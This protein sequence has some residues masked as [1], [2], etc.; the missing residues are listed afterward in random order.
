MSQRWGSSPS[1]KGCLASVSS[2]SATCAASL[3]AEEEAQR[4]GYMM[5]AYFPDAGLTKCAGCMMRAYFP[6]AGPYRRDLYPNL[7][8]K[9]IVEFFSAAISVSVCR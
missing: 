9:T 4:A 2:T 8:G 5:R 1:A 6:D 3:A 7:S